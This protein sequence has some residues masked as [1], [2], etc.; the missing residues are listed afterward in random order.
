MEVHKASS[1]ACLYG[2]V[3]QLLDLENALRVN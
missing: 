1:F 2:Q 3:E